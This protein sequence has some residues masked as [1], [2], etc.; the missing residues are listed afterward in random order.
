M[1]TENLSCLIITPNLSGKVIPVSVRPNAVALL[2]QAVCGG[3]T[4]TVAIHTKD[5]IN[6]LTIDVQLTRGPKTMHIRERSRG[7]ADLASN[8]RA[9]YVAKPE[10]IYGFAVCVDCELDER[11]KA[12]Q[13]DEVPALKLILKMKQ[14]LAAYARRVAR[15]QLAMQTLSQS[16][17]SGNPKN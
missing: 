9:S 10:H 2:L 7:T 6:A 1:R 13:L 12:G 14:N 3:N 8:N 5:D 17:T 4:D 16:P 15:K 11:T